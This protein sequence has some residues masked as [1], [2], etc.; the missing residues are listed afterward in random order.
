MSEN[1]NSKPRKSK[2]TL[3]I[4]IGLEICSKLFVDSTTGQEYAAIKVD[5]GL[6]DPDSRFL[7]VKVMQVDGEEFKRT[8]PTRFT[9]NMVRMSVPK[10]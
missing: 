3:L 6:P 2:A 7:P 4:E 5:D 9:R 1:N 10:R 8:L